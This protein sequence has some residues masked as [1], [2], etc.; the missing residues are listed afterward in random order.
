[1]TSYVVIVVT[2]CHLGRARSLLPIRVAP[3]P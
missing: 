3:L 2:V 1:M